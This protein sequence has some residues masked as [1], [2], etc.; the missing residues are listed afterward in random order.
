[1]MAFYFIVLCCAGTNI[2]NNEEVA[3]KLVSDFN[4]LGFGLYRTLNLSDFVFKM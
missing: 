4:Q 1:M 2:Q 3:V